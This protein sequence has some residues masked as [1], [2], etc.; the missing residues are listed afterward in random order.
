M[1]ASVSAYL[2]GQAQKS[3]HDVDAADH[4]KKL[5][6]DIALAALL[7][8]GIAPSSVDAVGCVDPLS[9]TYPD[10]ARSVAADIG[11]QKDVREFW[12][13]GGGTTPQDLT[14]EIALAIDAGEINIAV[15]FGA[16][17]MRTRRKATRAG[18]ELDWPAR[19]KSILA[20]RGQKP[21]TSEWEAQHGLRLPIQSFP[22]LENAMRA[23]GGHSAEEQISIAANLLHKNALVAES[24][25]HAWFQNAPSLMI[26]ARSPPTT[27]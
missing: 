24:N 25:P 2:L 9:W 20:M 23:A 13:P 22:I 12:L 16:E 21:F 8:A 15:I 11:C 17:A 19:D 3:F 1:T 10:L 14:H 26:L 5:M 4:P 27:E 6:S 7:D 18:K